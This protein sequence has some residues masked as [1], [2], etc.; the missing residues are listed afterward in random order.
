MPDR[1][2]HFTV[3]APCPELSA[4]GT[5]PVTVTSSTWSSLGWIIDHSSLPAMSMSLMPSSVMLMALDGS[6][7]TLEDRMLWLPPVSTPGRLA[8]NAEPFWVTMGRL[9]I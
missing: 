2:T 8:M 7:L 9:L 6:P 3:T 4:P 5:A 1:V